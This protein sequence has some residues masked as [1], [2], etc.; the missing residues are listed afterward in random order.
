MEINNC[1]KNL[2]ANHLYDLCRDKNGNHVYQKL[3]KVYHNETEE[4]NN[5]LYDYLADIALDVALLQ[6]GATI[7][8]TA[9][10]FGTYN[11]KEKICNKIIQDL[12]KLINN[13]YGN[14][15]VQAIINTLKE[16]KKLIEQIYK[17]ISSNIVE[18][19]KQKYS[20]NVLDAF[21]MKK[22]EFS[23]MIIDDIIKNNQVKDIIKDQYGNYVI[24]K[25]MSISDSDTLNK[26]VE[27]I[28]PIVPELLLSNL[29]KKILNKLMQQYNIRFQEGNC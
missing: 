19:S 27:Q 4:I 28:K 16:E 6:Q 25:A 9:I 8:T 3:L 5:F 20:S 26:I 17:Y 7:Y 15:S 24:Q 29:G 21:I 11:Q 2:I 12:D 22:D 10:N 18:L 1:I 23:K 14:Y 13:K